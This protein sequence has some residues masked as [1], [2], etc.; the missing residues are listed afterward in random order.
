MFLS[1]Y[2]PEIFRSYYHWQMWCPCKRSRS[3]VRVTE[4]KTSLS[5]FRPV[6]PFWI[7]IWWWNDTQNLMLEEVPYC[8]SRSSIKFQGHTAEK[9]HRF[10]PKLGVSR[11][12][13]IRW[14]LWNNA[15]SLKQHRS[16]V[17]LFFKVIHQISRSQGTKISDFDPNWAFPDCTSGLNSMTLKLCTKLNMV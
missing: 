14:W 12:F 9:N 3:K 4:V 1:S 15:Q 2:H 10:W 13:W 7:Y 17:L 5:L 16:G 6:T 8:F 11:L